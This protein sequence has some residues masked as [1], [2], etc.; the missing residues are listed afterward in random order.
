[1]LSYQD[2]QLELAV[3]KLVDHEI[4]RD[5]HDLIITT[6]SSVG[7]EDVLIVEASNPDY[8]NILGLVARVFNNQ[9][10]QMQIGA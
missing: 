1:M 3:F 9:Q 6:K 7:F 5:T 8:N 2:V 4:V 10:I